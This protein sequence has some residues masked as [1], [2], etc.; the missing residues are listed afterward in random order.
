MHAYQK[1]KIKLTEQEGSPVEI[2]MWKNWGAR[3]SQSFG[4][5][6]FGKNCPRA[7]I[8][9]VKPTRNGPRKIKF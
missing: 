7:L 9:F 1:G 3:Q 8:V 2:S 5:V 6:N 4:E